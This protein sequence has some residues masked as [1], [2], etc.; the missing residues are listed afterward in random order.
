VGGKRAAI[1]LG[2]HIEI[3]TRHKRQDTYQLD[4]TKDWLASDEWQMPLYAIPNIDPG[5]TTVEISQLRKPFTQ[6]HVEEMRSHL[7]ET[8]A[9]F[10]QNGCTITLNGPNVSGKR[11]RCL[12]VP[13]RVPTT[14]R[15]L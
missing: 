6:A 10:L 11:L 4:I 7:G 5:T 3:K 14:H 2:E 15:N 12:G 1:A 9:W 8:Y 13:Q